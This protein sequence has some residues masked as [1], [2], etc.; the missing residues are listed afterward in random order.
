[1]IRMAT[2]RPNQTSGR[3]VH[4]WADEQD[5]RPA[6]RGADHE[7]GREVE[8]LGKASL[9]DERAFQLPNLLNVWVAVANKVA[10]ESAKA[11]VDDV[12]EAAAD[13]PR[14]SRKAS[15]LVERGQNAPRNV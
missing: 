7:R 15:R 3:C 2:G 11:T 14:Q 10:R 13:H 5:F 1:M 12:T 4:T 6:K 8:R 9:G